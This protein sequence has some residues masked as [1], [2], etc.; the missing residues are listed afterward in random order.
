MSRGAIIVPCSPEGFPT[1]IEGKAE[2]VPGFR[3]PFANFESFES[4]IT[5][6]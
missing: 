4:E 3:N 6:V 1:R 2:I 5:G